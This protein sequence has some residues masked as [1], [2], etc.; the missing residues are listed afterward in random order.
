VPD[1]GKDEYVVSPMPAFLITHPQGNVL[2]D[3]GPN[4]EVFKDGPSVWGGLVKAFQP[5]GDHESGI[6][7]QLKKIGVSPDEV[8]Y[9]VN[10]HLHFDHVGGNRFFPK[11]IF[12]V[13][14]MEMEYARQPE[15]EGK[16]Y[17]SA[18]WDIP[19]DYR[20]IKGQ[21]DIFDDGRL[22]IYPMPGH[23]PGHQGML[24]RLDR[25]GVIIL[26]GDSTPCRENF[27]HRLVSRNNLDNEQT[28]LTIER[29]HRLSAEEKATVIY[30]HDQ[31]QWE[32]L[33]KA[34]EYYD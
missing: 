10:S 13:S 1:A 19:L 30:G 31:G 5:V 3:T 25:E 8:K 12:L 11:A 18:D 15:L 22:V 24:I 32:G 2:F 7:S 21:F 6:V 33:K 27:E 28:R 14:A 23:T 26:S 4:P 29:L 9:V 16:G 34:P 20:P 17:F